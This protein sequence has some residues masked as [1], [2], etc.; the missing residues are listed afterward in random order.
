MPIFATSS[1]DF[2][3]HPHSEQHADCVYDMANR[4]S[5]LGPHDFAAAKELLSD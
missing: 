3:K 2:Q 4:I 5:E 1:R